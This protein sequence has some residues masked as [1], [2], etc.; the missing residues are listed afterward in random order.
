MRQDPTD[1]TGV[2][3]DSPRGNKEVKR[4]RDRKANAALQLHIAGLIPDEIAEQLGYPDGGAVR[5]AIELALERELHEE[6]RNEMRKMVGLRLQR[7][8]KAVWAKAIDP[9]S[10]EQL[11]AQR[12]ARANLAEFTRVFGLAAPTEMVVHTPTAQELENW[13]TT[14]VSKSVPQLEEADIFEGEVLEDSITI[15]DPNGDPDVTGTPDPPT[16]PIPDPDPIEF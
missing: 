5:V 14:V 11:A 2:F 6:S 3:D 16:D 7:L 9:S 4:A 1:P 15:P 8:T 13:V 12:E 10:P